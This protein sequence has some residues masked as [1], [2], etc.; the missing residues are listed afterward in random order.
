MNL[1]W[2]TRG[3]IAGTSTPATKFSPSLTDRENTTEAG[4]SKRGRFFY[5]IDFYNNLDYAEHLEYG[6]RNHFRPAS[7]CQSLPEKRSPNGMYGQGSL[8]AICVATSPFWRR[9]VKRTR[10][11]NNRPGLRAGQSGQRKNE[12]AHSAP[13]HCFGRSGRALLLRQ[14]RPGR[15]LWRARTI[16]FDAGFSLRPATRPL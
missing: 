1:A 10:T 12:I 16:G 4:R 7:I 11:H 3:I 14:E 8:V 2:W 5:K 9:A 15:R 13:W 6:F